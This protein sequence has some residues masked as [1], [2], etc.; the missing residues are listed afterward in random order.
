MDYSNHASN[1]LLLSLDKLHTTDMGIDRIKKNLSIDT[2][3]V[4]GWC[5]KKIKNPNSSINRKGKNWYVTTDND[6]IT[7]N[8]H[9]YTIITAHK[10]KKAE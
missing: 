6:I 7:I 3:D 10:V 5:K 2:E 4:V 1:P 9:S 8:A